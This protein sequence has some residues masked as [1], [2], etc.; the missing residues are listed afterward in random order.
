MVTIQHKGVTHEIIRREPGEG[1]G[2]ERV[3]T[4]DGTW[5]STVSHLPIKGTGDRQGISYYNMVIEV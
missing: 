1:T 2:D 5:W 4:S 3:L